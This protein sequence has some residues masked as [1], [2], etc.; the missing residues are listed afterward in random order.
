METLK[1]FLFIGFLFFITPGFSVAQSETYLTPLEAQKKFGNAKF[2]SAKFKAAS[3]KMKG[4]MAADMILKKEFI[5]K[6]FNSVRELL[7]SPDGYFENDAIPAY[8]ISQDVDK[9]DTWQ[10][11]FLPDKNWKKIDEVKIHK[12]CCN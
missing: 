2:D 4:E 6:P 10:I 11:I 7:G 9:K 5:G 1:K 12:N 8:I 3:L